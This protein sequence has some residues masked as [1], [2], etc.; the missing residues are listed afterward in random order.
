[1]SLGGPSLEEKIEES[2]SDLRKK[3]SKQEIPGRSKMGHDELAATVDLE[4]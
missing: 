3:A 4:N 1:V 2:T